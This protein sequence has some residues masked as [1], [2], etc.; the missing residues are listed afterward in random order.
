M[1]RN[2]REVPSSPKALYNTSTL[3]K[4]I[5]YHQNIQ[6]R[7]QLADILLNIQRRIQLTDILLNIQRRIQLADILLN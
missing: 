3:N 5:N 7:I 6:R 2:S 4:Q 1:C